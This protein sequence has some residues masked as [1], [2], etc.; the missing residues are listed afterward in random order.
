L[1]QH[2]FRVEPATIPKESL[3]WTLKAVTA[4]VEDQAHGIIGMVHITKG[5]LGAINVP[6]PPPD[7][8]RSVATFLGKETAKID[9]L[10][11]EQRRLIELLKEKRQAVISHAVA[12]SEPTRQVT[13]VQLNRNR[14]R[15]HVEPGEWAVLKLSA[16]KRGEFDGSKVKALPPEAN[17]PA[18][19]ELRKGDFLITRANT[20]ELV[21]DSCY[22]SN[23]P[24][25]LIFS[26][27]IYRIVLRK[28]TMSGEF[29][30]LV[31]QSA[32]GRGQA[33]RDARGSSQSMVKL[34]HDHVLNWLVP[35]P[36][37]HEQEKIVRKT[38][39]RLEELNRVGDICNQ[40]IDLLQE[41]RSALISAAVTG[42][43]D[44]RNYTPKEAA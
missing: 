34:G 20:P 13:P 18:H 15:H 7:E 39:E 31:I 36:P 41:R 3:Y 5:D 43:I 37:L 8:H 42:K 26:D 27:L 23:L 25:Q 24:Q 16:V 4:H 9:A 17:I 40:T 21:G 19:L 11:G 6:I 38:H 22:V 29:L 2:I 14:L 1:N 12:P 30:N 32:L 44:V 33:K 10:I 35:A 28:D